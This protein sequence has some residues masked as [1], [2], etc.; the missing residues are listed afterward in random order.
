MNSQKLRLVLAA[1]I[2]VFALG[3]LIISSL[4][5]ARIQQVMPVPPVA[6]PS[7]TPVSLWLGWKVL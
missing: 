7:L 3:I 2:L 6:L 1:V 4:P 5:A